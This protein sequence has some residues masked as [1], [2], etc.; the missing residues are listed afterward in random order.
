MSKITTRVEDIPEK[1]KEVEWEFPCLGGIKNSEKYIV[2]F[3]QDK[4][5]LRVKTDDQSENYGIGTIET[6]WD[7]SAFKPCKNKRATIIIEC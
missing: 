7:M 6:D 4:I 2:Y 5:G 3:T 1:K